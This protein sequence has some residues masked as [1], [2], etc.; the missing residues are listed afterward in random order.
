MGLQR[1]GF[2]VFP[3]ARLCPLPMLSTLPLPCLSL[4]V[5]IAA[6]RTACGRP[7]CA[8]ARLGVGSY[9]P[10]LR[11]LLQGRIDWKRR[12]QA[13]GKEIALLLRHSHTLEKNACAKLL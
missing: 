7:E 4:P 5:F 12:S 10:E 2:I 9:P 6:R 11:A 13:S 1:N 8:F 3:K